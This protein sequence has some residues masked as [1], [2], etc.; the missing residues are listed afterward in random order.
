MQSNKPR[1][2]TP[3][4]I[5]RELWIWCILIVLLAALFGWPALYIRNHPEILAT[6][7]R[8]GSATMPVTETIHPTPI[9]T[10]AGPT[11]DLLLVATQVLP[12]APG[13]LGVVIAP[14]AVE[15]RDYPEGAGLQSQNAGGIYLYPGETVEAL[16]CQYLAD[17]VWVLH[18]RGWSI[19]RNA[20]SEFITKV[21]K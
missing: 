16:D 1:S 3:R 14:E 4:V 21:C 6:Y 5:L 17:S 8:Q 20:S 11:P 7:P 9:R 15:I 2:I 10:P 12:V 18:S 13:V 19:A